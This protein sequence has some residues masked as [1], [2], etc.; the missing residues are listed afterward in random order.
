MDE[1]TIKIS[2]TA[3]GVEIL[4]KETR[5]QGFSAVDVY[6]LRHKLFAGGWT[7]ELVREN[8]VRRDMCAC[9][10]LDVEREEIVFVRQFRLGA[11][12]SAHSP[13]VGGGGSPWTLE[14][15]AGLIEK[16]ETPEE[17]VIREVSEE[18]GC[19]TSEVELISRYLPSHGSS[20]EFAFVFCGRTN[21]EGA[22]GICGNQAEGEDI[23]VEV[24]S[25][26]NA[27]R[28]LENGLFDNA[29]T[30]IA[31]QWLKL[32]YEDLLEKWRA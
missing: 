17:V 21:A 30:L 23:F 2:M 11:Y 19:Q 24:M 32:N 22:G 15:P 29:I 14:I 7:H 26:Q 9:L 6:R 28:H 3:D 31:M 27:F 16:G 18:T 13:Y 8:S 12:V 5:Y 1:K 4:D 10:P 25:V 20:S